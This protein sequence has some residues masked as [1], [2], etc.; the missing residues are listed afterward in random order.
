M[1]ICNVCV[2]RLIKIIASAL[3]G[4]M[5]AY[6]LIACESTE[7][8]NRPESCI[9]IY[10]TGFHFSNNFFRRRRRSCWLFFL[11]LFCSHRALQFTQF[12]CSA[13]HRDRIDDKIIIIVNNQQQHV[14]SSSYNCVSLRLKLRA[15]RCKVCALCVC[16]LHIYVKI[17]RSILWLLFGIQ[18]CRRV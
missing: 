18:P 11:L 7:S 4:C 16:I 17:T 12:H 8:H 10:E 2:C 5:C 6:R 15:P 3:R 14:C 9:A 13:P 1:Y